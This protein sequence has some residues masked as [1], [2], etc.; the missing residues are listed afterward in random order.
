MDAQASGDRVV[1]HILDLIARLMFRPH[2]AWD[3]ALTRSWGDHIGV[4][5]WSEQG[6]RWVVR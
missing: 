5:Q 6:H 2:I 4:R 1:E 3:V